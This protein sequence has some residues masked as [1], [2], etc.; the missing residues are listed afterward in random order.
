L[1]VGF[2]IFLYALLHSPG[3]ARWNAD[4][5]WRWYRDQK[6]MVGCNYINR[7]AVNTLEMW[8]DDFNATQIDDNWVGRPS[9]YK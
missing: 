1:I 7:D 4:Q 3:Q 8:G 5:A 9:N 2:A 6:W